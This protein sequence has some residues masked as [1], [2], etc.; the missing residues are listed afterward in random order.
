MAELE[1]L[2]LKSNSLSLCVIE[3]SNLLPNKKSN[4]V[5]FIVITFL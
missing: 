3:E 5:T 4:A 2:F 1:Q